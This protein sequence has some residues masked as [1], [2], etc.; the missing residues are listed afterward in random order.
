MT[1]TIATN[2]A[3]LWYI[4]VTVAVWDW[5]AAVPIAVV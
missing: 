3:R 4:A 1:P 2:V 5:D